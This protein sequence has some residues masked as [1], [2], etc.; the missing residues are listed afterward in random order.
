[1]YTTYLF[2]PSE[3]LY[4]VNRGQNSY[5]T[6]VECFYS[7]LSFSSSDLVSFSRCSSVDFLQ[8]LSTLSK[9]TDHYAVVVFGVTVNHAAMPLVSYSVIYGL[10]IEVRY[11][12]ARSIREFPI[13]F[14]GSNVALK[15]L[16]F[17]TG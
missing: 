4:A 7:Q 12:K 6:K 9:T 1:M 5:I 3:P 15:S 2:S 14:F 10:P 8:I 13:M 11:R 17:W 16:N